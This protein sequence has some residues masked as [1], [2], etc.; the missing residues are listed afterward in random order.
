MDKPLGTLIVWIK[1]SQ[2]KK[3]AYLPID[4]LGVYQHVPFAVCVFGFFFRERVFAASFPFL[5]T[6]F[7]LPVLLFF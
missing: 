5:G 2:R 6:L 3:K 1:F 4:D 7:F